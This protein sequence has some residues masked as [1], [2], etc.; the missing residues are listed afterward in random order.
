M[1]TTARLFRR[2]E[3]GR[4]KCGGGGI[5]END[6]NQ[7]LH[8]MALFVVLFQSAFCTFSPILVLALY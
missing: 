1:S 2:E 3:E 8:I 5:D 4:P 7:G 6:Y